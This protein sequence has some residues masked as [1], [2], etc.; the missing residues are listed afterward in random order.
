MGEAKRAR[1][2]AGFLPPDGYSPGTM[3]APVSYRVSHP[4][5]GILWMT[6]AAASYAVLTMAVRYAA[7]LVDPLEIAF[8][9]TLIILLI[10]AAWKAPVLGLLRTQRLGAHASRALLSMVTMTLM[11]L[12]LGML[13]LALVTALTFTAPLFATVGAALFLGEKVRLRRWLATLIG[14]VGALIIIRPHPEDFNLLLLLPLGTALSMAAVLLSI[15]SL[16]A[17]ESSNAIVFLN[18]L[19]MT[20]MALVPALFVWTWPPLEA[21]GWLLLAGVSAFGIQQC[22]TRAFACAEASLILPFDFGRL[23]FTGLVAFAMFGEQPDLWTLVGAVV[24]FA[25][26]LYIA[27]RETV[28][29]RADTKSSPIAPPPPS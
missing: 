11:F 9:R 24:V 28:H 5:R 15:R 17:T 22:M 1:N 12:S 29:A 14:F 6:A 10:M 8:F 23:I 3:S 7:P 27:H 25:A 26:G 18:A 21:W 19:L 20:P 2:G 4:L 16:T 13:P